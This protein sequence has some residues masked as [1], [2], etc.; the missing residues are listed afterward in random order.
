MA[1]SDGSCFTLGDNYND[2]WDVA[3]KGAWAAL[4]VASPASELAELAKWNTIGHVKAC[5]SVRKRNV[6]GLFWNNGGV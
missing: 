5:M 6:D 1:L 3:T 2:F 4:D